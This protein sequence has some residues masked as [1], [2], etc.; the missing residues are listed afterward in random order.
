MDIPIYKWFVT[1]GCQETIDTLKKSYLLYGN[2]IHH[3]LVKNRGL[4]T[5]EID[6]WAFERDEE[7]QLYMQE[8][9]DTTYT[10]DLP[11]LTAAN[12]YYEAL[13]KDNLPIRE[14]TDIK[15]AK[16][17][18]F[19]IAQAARFKKWRELSFEQLNSLPWENKADSS[20]SQ[21]KSQKKENL[22]DVAS[23]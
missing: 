20:V 18:G 2:N 7:L 11:F 23:S 5:T 19:L 13:K 14:V 16:E 17:L 9:K 21:E 12:S 15:K 22:S 10:I 8:Y 3:I 6:W 1:D 4:A